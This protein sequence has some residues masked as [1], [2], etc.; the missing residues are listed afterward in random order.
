M[1]EKQKPTQAIGKFLDMGFQRKGDKKRS[2]RFYIFVPPELVRDPKFP[3]QTNDPV[4][5]RLEGQ[6][7]TVIKMVPIE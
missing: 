7:L 4:M 1:D 5:I 6:K 2:E 3:F